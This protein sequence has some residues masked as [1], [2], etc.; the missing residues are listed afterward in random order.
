VRDSVEIDIGCWGSEDW[1]GSVC[2]VANSRGRRW[3]PSS[4]CKVVVAA[5]VVAAAV[6][7]VVVPLLV[8][9][10]CSPSNR[11]VVARAIADVGV[12]VVYSMRER[13]RVAV[14]AGGVDDVACCETGS[15]RM[16]VVIDVVAL[17]LVGRYALVLIVVVVVA[18]FCSAREW[19]IVVVIVVVIAAFFERERSKLAQ[20]AQLSILCSTAKE[21]EWHEEEKG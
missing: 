20:S 1:A 2:F 3:H 15:Q 11:V 10:K 8:V 12:G 19:K 13:R 7:L 4:R 14:N 21:C 6:V 9:L 5:V 16:K 17:A 18:V